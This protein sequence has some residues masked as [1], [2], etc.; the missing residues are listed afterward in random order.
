MGMLDKALQVGG[1]TGCVVYCMM[2]CMVYCMMY[3]MNRLHG[4]M[5]G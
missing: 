4:K 5:A 3:C 2:Y 1:N